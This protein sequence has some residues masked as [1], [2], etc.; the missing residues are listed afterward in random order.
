MLKSADTTLNIPSAS[1]DRQERIQPKKNGGKSRLSHADLLPECEQRLKDKFNL[2]DLEK[3]EVKSIINGLKKNSRELSEDIWKL[4]LGEAYKS[5]ECGSWTKFCIQHL[6]NI[7]NPKE[8]DRIVRSVTVEKRLGIK[9]G[10]LVQST[11][12]KLYSLDDEAL[13]T[14]WR[15]ANKVCEDGNFP[16]GK[17]IEDAVEKYEQF[18]AML[19]LLTTASDRQKKLAFKAIL[20]NTSLDCARSLRTI[21]KEHMEV[22]HA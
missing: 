9:V 5:Y 10:T 13:N 16:T 8:I 14:V 6:S 1:S 12:R 4:K 18:Q 19:K 7:G 11:T 21:L 17:Q 3:N 15:M 22:S 20:A 2:G